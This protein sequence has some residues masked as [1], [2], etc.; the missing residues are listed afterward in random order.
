[1]KYFLAKKDAK[2][3]LIRWIL[4]LQEF[5]LEIKDKKGIEN[6]VADHLS[7]MHSEREVT[8]PINESFL[9]ES[10]WSVSKEDW[11]WYADIV[12]YLCS[13][14]LPH[15]YTSQQKKR[16][17]ASLKDFLWDDPL[18][19]K[20]C[21]YGIIRRCVPEVEI[22]SVIQHCHSQPTG[23]HHSAERTVAKI[24]Q[25]GFYWPTMF[26]DAR[27][28][29]IT[30]DQCQ[31]T[32]NIGKKQEMLQKPILEVEIFDV[33][34]LDFMGPFPSSCGNQY[35]LVAVDYVSKWVEAIALPTNRGKDVVR[36]VKKN[37]FSRFG[38]PRAILSD[39]GVHFQNYQFRSLL[40]KYGCKFKT[41]TPYHPQSSG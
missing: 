23:G 19:F 11:P 22:P 15:D 30:C 29:V 34:G 33:W 5:D 32:G 39:N 2:P 6:T 25:C 16:F 7:R 1:M 20:R 26:K 8:L 12:N 38:V 40:E 13:N 4:L 17:F 10:L 31:R 28:F 14:K 18:L 27:A 3:R 37:I 21:P 9:D 36:F 35:I 41:G 24:L